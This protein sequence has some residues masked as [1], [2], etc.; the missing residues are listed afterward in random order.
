VFSWPEGGQQDNDHMANVGKTGGLEGKSEWL[1]YVARFWNMS[2]MA[3]R[4]RSA[5]GRSVSTSM[6]Y[7]LPRVKR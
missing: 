1:D 5:T 6:R 2:A 3:G 4:Y 7:A